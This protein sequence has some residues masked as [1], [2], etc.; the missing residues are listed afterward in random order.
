MKLII[1]EKPS[2]AKTIAQTLG[3][4]RYTEDYY[5]VDDWTITWAYGHLLTLKMPEDYNPDYK[6]WKLEDLPIKPKKFEFEPISPDHKKRLEA[7]KKLWKQADVVYCATDAGREG[8]LIFRLIWD[9]VGDKKKP[10]KRVWLQTLTPNG[11][12]NAINEAKDISNYD[13][14]YRAALDRSLAD[15][16]VG[17]N[18]T[19]AV[20]LKQNQKGQVFSIGRVQT[21]TLAIITK[22]EEEIQKFSSKLSYRPILVFDGYQ[23][24]CDKTFPTKEEA[25]NFVKPLV[26]KEV[27]LKFEQ[28][29]TKDAPALLPSLADLQ[30]EM[31][32]KAKKTLDTLQALY[33]KQLVSY[34]RTD[35]NYLPEDM[36]TQVQHIV[37]MLGDSTD[38]Q[39]AK[40]PHDPKRIYDN[41]KVSDHY[42]VIPLTKP[43][44]LS[45]DEKTLFEYI[46]KRFLSV[47]YPPAVNTVQTVSCE[48]KG[49]KFS[50]QRV[51]TKDP[52]WYK[53]F[54]DKIKSDK[55]IP[56]VNK[57]TVIDRKVEKVKTNPPPRWTD[58][59]LI[60][61]MEHAGRF[62]DEKN[63]KD[64]IRD[65][66]IGTP[67]TRADIIERL[68]SVGYVQRN[69]RSLV[70][71]D[72][73]MAIIQWLEEHGMGEL[74]KPELTAEWED[75]LEQITAGKERADKFLPDII[76]WTQQLISRTNE[77]TL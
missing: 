44:G 30:K 59:T 20:T 74:T 14:L 47:F 45:G 62:I 3:K 26:G 46:V 38:K 42:A 31:P 24:K 25:L 36:S 28:K 51:S 54:P 68:I 5:Q 43:N 52:S 61:A 65:K 48:Y 37:A 32:W 4:P 18:L 29:E 40:K 39:Y 11:I 69:K 2:V 23:L 33:E 6:K 64:A 41:N 75:R 16:I 49:V 55:F 76:Y 72:K 27:T 77:R 66:G 10:V 17:I 15:W 7:I 57:A 12:K 63:L 19:R 71:T 56:E 9:Y 50:T 34:P 53:H 21:P 73:G 22:R 1:T 8:E 60:D 58:S 70:P 67:A 35:S 13:N